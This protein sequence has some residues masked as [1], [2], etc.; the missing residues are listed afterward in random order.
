MDVPGFIKGT[1]VIPK[2]TSGKVF[3]IMKKQ[4]FMKISHTFQKESLK[5][6]I[7]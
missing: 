6:L 5:K 4:K 7:D 2:K 3:R 1:K